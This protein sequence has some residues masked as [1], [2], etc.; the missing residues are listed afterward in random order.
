[1][2]PISAA[3]VSPNSGPIPRDRLE[4]GHARVGAGERAQLALQRSEALVEPVNHRERLGDRASPHLGHPARLEQLHR[5][6]L[7]QPGDRQL[8]TPLGQH[9]V[10]AVA[11]HGAH[12][13]Q[14]H[15]A[16]EPLT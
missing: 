3:M 2:S 8:Q 14:L 12:A 16:L 9:A 7:T 1:M 13:D 15:A 6:G 5:I 10:D 4:P 11:S